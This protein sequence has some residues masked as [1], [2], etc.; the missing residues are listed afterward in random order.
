MT[1]TAEC[2][3]DWEEKFST[4]HNTPYWYNRVTSESVWTRPATAK[5]ERPDTI[6][7]SNVKRSR[8]EFVDGRL[9][10]MVKS[11]YQPP[12]SGAAEDILR[13][14]SKP[15]TEPRIIPDLPNSTVSMWERDDIMVNEYLARVYKEGSIEDKKGIKQK[16]KDI[17]NPVQGRHLYNL[18]TENKFTRT[19][20]V[21]LA[22][23]KPLVIK[24]SPTFYN[25][26]NVKGRVLYG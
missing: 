8:S 19:L 1:E 16:F 26:S 24:I 3:S 22:M 7:S 20:E 4:K 11:S 13:M 10:S 2:P 15:L 5:R 6:E 21:G 14:K 18:I 9:A 17:T 25:S 23:G 12:V